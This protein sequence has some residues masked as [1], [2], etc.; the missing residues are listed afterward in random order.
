MGAELFLDD[1][2]DGRVGHR[3]CVGLQCGEGAAE[4]LGHEADVD[5]GEHL[6]ELHGRALHLA[7]LAGDALGGGHEPLVP[8]EV[9][10]DVADRAAAHRAGLGHRGDRRALDDEAGRGDRSPHSPCG[11]PP[12]SHCR[13]R[14]GGARSGR[15][16]RQAPYPDAVRGGRLERWLA[17]RAVPLELAGDASLAP[18]AVLDPVLD[19]ARLAYV[20][21]SHHFVT[22]KYAFRTL[23]LRALAARGW[24][25]FGEELGWSDGLLVDEHLRTGDDAPLHRI[26][27]Y[28]DEAW[29]RTDR[30]DRPTG[31]LAAGERDYPTA[32]LAHEQRAFARAVRAAIPGARWFGFDID[33]GATAAHPALRSQLGTP[34]PHGL[35]PVPG[36]TMEEEAARVEA[37]LAAHPELPVRTRRTL[38]A[39][40][41][42]LRYAVEAHPAPAWEDLSPPLATREQLM[43][44]H[45]DAVLDEPELARGE[46]VGLLAGSL[47]LLKDDDRAS[48]LSRLLGPGGGRVPSIGHHVAH[49]ADVG[50]GRVAAVWMLCGSGRDSNPM[51]TGAQEVEPRRGTLNAALARVAAGRPLLVPLAGLEGEVVVQHMY[52]ATFATPAAGQLDA[53]VFAPTVG[54]LREPD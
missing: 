52:G 29:R 3:G 6:A 26:P 32:A 45:V 15:Q 2:D 12:I 23:V 36:E 13:R 17:A 46:R 11:Q 42:T 44:R 41:G 38:D 47:H 50:P 18:L 16:P 51:V 43:H 30:D 40:A 54:P 34:L 8:G 39:L 35:E 1:L 49:R 27:T 33:G 21:E 31:V 7:E 5:E 4:L 10:R 19:G 24:R 9:G 25:W 37:V 28:G 14:Y 48:E 22:E 53:V 20:V